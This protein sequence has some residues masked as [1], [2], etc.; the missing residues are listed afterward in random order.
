MIKSVEVNFGEAKLEFKCL[1]GCEEEYSLHTLQNVLPPKMFSKIAQKKA[2]AEVK[3]A[4]IEQLESCP[5]CDFAIIPGENDK[6]FRCLNPDCMKES[7]RSCKEP[8]HVPLRCDEVEHDAEVKTRVFIENR[9]T[10]A[11]LR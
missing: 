7:C 10:E 5:F 11:L 9:M 8:N 3:A 1:T 4:G 2:L 6:I